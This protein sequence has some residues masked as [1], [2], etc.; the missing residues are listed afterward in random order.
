MLSPVTYAAS[1]H[2]G[3]YQ[4]T[5]TTATL[6]GE[7]PVRGCSC[8]FCRAHAARYTSDPSG[9]VALALS[10]DP[11]N[12]YRFGSNSVDFLICRDCGVLLG[13]L[14]GFSD[15]TRAMAL[16]LNALRDDLPKLRAT[17][18]H[19]FQDEAAEERLARRKRTWTPVVG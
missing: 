8:T 2:C 1:C 16:N 9:T 14:T 6:P 10:G 18:T 12:H 4:L 7:W 3:A 13:A 11:V 15:G 19:E 5:F 17:T